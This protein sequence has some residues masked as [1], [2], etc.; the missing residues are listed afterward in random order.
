[1]LGL[2][3]PYLVALSTWRINA[4]AMTLPLTVI[5]G[6][7]G[8]G[9]TTLLK[10]LLE[11]ADGRRLAVL[12]ND[13]GALNIDAALIKSTGADSVELSNGCV[14]C[15][16]GDDLVKQ[17]VILERSADQF[18]HVVIEASGVGD[19][20]KIAQIGMVAG[21][22][23][24]DS[25][26]V[27]VDTETIEAHLTDELISDTVI[28]QLARA[29]IVLANKSDLTSQ[30]Q[31]IKISDSVRPHLDNDSHHWIECVNG[32][33]DIRLALGDYSSDRGGVMQNS[34]TRSLRTLKLPPMFEALSFT[35]PG[36]QTRADLQALFNTFPVGVWSKL[37]RGKAIVKTMEGWIEWHKM[38]K[39]ENWIEHDGKAPSTTH[40]VLICRQL[41]EAVTE[42]LIAAG[43]S[44]F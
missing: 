35:H 36:V 16:L 42:N 43:W 13:F 27:V 24:L 5:G 31:R 25:V 10:H 1:M 41:D 9:K 38:G 28:R 22:Y 18:D 44:R 20:W 15:S 21:A 17:L 32:Q 12:I 14:C 29:D 7:L 19:P 34:F 2:P 8:A 3:V 37:L 23:R 4:L 33:L 30:A 11:N 39:R 40:L 6:F 26:I